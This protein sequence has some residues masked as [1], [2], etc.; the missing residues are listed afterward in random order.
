MEYV[1]KLPTASMW[2]Y[3]KPCDSELWVKMCRLW[4]LRKMEQ[5]KKAHSSTVKPLYNGTG[6]KVPSFN[7]MNMTYI[8]PYN[9]IG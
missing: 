5:I 8:K 4:N 2:A 3:N 7:Y 6:T 9:G 1:T